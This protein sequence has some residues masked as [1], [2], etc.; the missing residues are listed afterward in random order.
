MRDSSFILIEVTDVILNFIENSLPER[1][2]ATRISGQHEAVGQILTYP[3][4][5]LITQLCVS[6]F[7]PNQV[8]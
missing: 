5:I 7:L 2:N 6:L 3:Q 8:F 4:K 1:K